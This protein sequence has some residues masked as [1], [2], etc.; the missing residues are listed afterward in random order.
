MTR[1]EERRRR[2]TVEERR[3]Q[4]AE[5]SV[6]LVA[7]YGSY[8][9]S[10]QLVADAVGLSLPGLLHH[11]RS[12]EELL[13][14]IIELHFD[15]RP[16]GSHPLDGSLDEAASWPRFLRAII[17]RNAE[18]PELTAVYLTLAVEAHDPVHP[19]HAYY[20]SRHARIL[21]ELA[22]R[23]WNVPQRFRESD[24]LADLVRTSLSALDGVQLQALT[25]P[26]EDARTL[27]ARVERTL[28]GGAEWDDYR[29]EG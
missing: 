15:A 11:V 8:G 23:S 3:R 10:M 21:D 18:R 2:L 12:R 1:P 22:R 16:D 28:F 26:R 6:A 24:A 17:E 20:E 9:V 7:K 14:M 27:W 29:G 4:I 19:A 5:R 25:D 13:T